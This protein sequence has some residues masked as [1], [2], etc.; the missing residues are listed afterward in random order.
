M[1]SL[2]AAVSKNNVIGN[3]NEIPWYLPADLKHFA[4]VT[5]SH[6]VIMGRKT[7]ESILARLGKPLPERKNIVITR[8]EN[9][10][11][12]DCVVVNSLE[13][14][15]R[16]ID[17]T[18]EVFIIGGEEIYRQAISLSDKLYLTEVDFVSE[19]N[20]FFPEWNKEEWRL[21]K[22][23]SHLPDEKNKHP[24]TFQEYERV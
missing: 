12:P 23:E 18:E 20:V 7:Y 6:S 2:I 24:Y 14:A 17:S 13:E 16:N 22:S 15:L 8:Q 10:N 19:G 3:K 9:F 5:K 4:S 1:I 21:I 11:A